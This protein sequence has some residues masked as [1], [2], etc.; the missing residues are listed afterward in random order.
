MDT[1]KFTLLQILFTAIVSD[2]NFEGYSINL[3]DTATDVEYENYTVSTTEQCGCNEISTCVRK[4]CRSGFYH[5]HDENP[6]TGYYNS[7]CIRNETPRNFSVSIFKGTDKKYDLNDGFM[8]GML[9]CDNENYYQYFKMD[10]SDPRQKFFIQENGSLYYQHYG[11]VYKNDRYCVDER[12]GL[13]AFVCFIPPVRKLSTE[14]KIHVAAKLVPLPFLLVTF[15][16]YLVIPESNL[17]TKSLMAHIFML[18]FGYITWAIGQSQFI[19]HGHA[20]DALGFSILFSMFSSFFWMNVICIDIWWAFSGLTNSY[21]RRHEQNALFG[22]FCIYACGIPGLI[23]II[24]YLLNIY[25]DKDSPYYPGVGYGACFING[26]FQI[27][28]YY[29]GPILLMILINVVLFVLT[30]INIQRIKKD[31]AVLQESEN[32]KNSSKDVD[33][34]VKLY[35]KLLFAMGINPVVNTHLIQTI[36]WVV[37]WKVSEDSAKYIWYFKD[38]AH[39]SYGIV[40]FII[41]VCK[42]K[43]WKMLKKR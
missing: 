21:G 33:E 12:D 30:A 5:Y 23:V 40:I 42:K 43:I 29:F 6:Q 14:R 4:C 15:I 17:H 18:F 10:N 28:F 38:F 32:N 3:C 13:T 22:L 27:L 8:I 24:I 16:V 31:T 37:G 26:D 2:A 25:L 9:N 39:A 20:C 11:K 1:F 35:W 36:S 7:V 41:F 34:K 19:E